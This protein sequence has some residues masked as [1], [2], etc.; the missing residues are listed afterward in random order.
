MIIKENAEKIIKW[1]IK[2]FNDNWVVASESDIEQQSIWEK[3][4]LIFHGNEKYNEIT[5]RE[6]FQAKGMMD[7]NPDSLTSLFKSKLKTEAGID[8]NWTDPKE[9]LSQ[10]KKWEITEITDDQAEILAKYESGSL[11]LDWLEKITENQAEIISHFKWFSIYLRWL[12][13][14]SDDLLELLMLHGWVRLNKEFGD[15]LY[16]IENNIREIVNKINSWEI[17]MTDEHA[18]LLSKQRLI[19]QLW[20]KKISDK[21]FEIISKYNANL[22][23]DRLETITDKQAEIIHEKW[24]LISLKWLTH[25]SDKQ[26]DIFSR[27]NLKNVKLPREI[28][29]KIGDIRMEISNLSEITDSQ[30]DQLYMDKSDIFSMATKLSDY[31][32]T[33]FST[34]QWKWL[35]FNKLETLSDYQIE[36]L[37]NFKWDKLDLGDVKLTPHNA[38]LLSKFK[39]E[40]NAFRGTIKD[41]SEIDYTSSYEILDALKSKEITTITDKHAELLAKHRDRVLEL[42]L[43]NLSDIHVES[44]VKFNWMSLILHWLDK[45]TDNQAATLATFWWSQLVLNWLKEISETQAKSLAEYSGF[46]LRIWWITELDPNQLKQLAQYKCRKLVLRSNVLDAVNKIR[47]WLKLDPT[48]NELINNL[49]K[50]KQLTD[51]HVEIL[52]KYKG[53]VLNLEKIS[54]ITDK[55]AE[56]LVK[57]TWRGLNL[58]W[59]KKLS[60]EQAEIWS[61]FWW[62]WIMFNWLTELTDDK[63]AYHLASN[64]SWRELYLNWL[65][66]ITDK[67]RNYFSKF[68]WRI[69]SSINI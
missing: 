40:I 64:W 46:E 24:F 1:M 45:I 65:T 17:E 6:L 37:A 58:S 4:V 30:A 61:K 56:L 20:I 19:L 43:S 13:N 16:K 54:E 32:A 42:R 2:T 12:T 10:I 52:L 53:W 55:H 59:L 38:R 15:K 18:E 57:F 63:I 14:I 28:E 47:K 11:N 5:A 21:Q 7:K 3:F 49:R 48:P 41:L 31:Q 69:A 68:K 27:T 36:Q 22:M 33:K 66:K 67:Q 35:Y 25:I 50:I 51:K 44:L 34:F 29:N 23:L 60:V 8:G 9:L 26:L 62:E 39:W